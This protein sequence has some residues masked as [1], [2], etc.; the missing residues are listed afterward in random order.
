MDF[1]FIKIENVLFLFMILLANNET[2]ECQLII[3]VSSGEQGAVSYRQTVSGNL[4]SETVSVQWVTPAGNGVYQLTDFKA[5]VTITSI[6]VPGELDMGLPGYQ[7]FC[8]VTPGTG[9]IIPAE[10][11]FKLRQK[12]REAVRVAEE[13]K[14]RVVVDNSLSLVVSRSH[15]IS[16]HI[17][18]VCQEAKQNTFAPEQLMKDYLDGVVG[19]KKDSK[20]DV[21]SYLSF[22]EKYSG[23]RRCSQLGYE[24][25]EE[26]CL[27]VLNS[28][29][30]W[31]PCSLKYCRNNNGEAREHRCGIKTCSKCSELRF[32]SRSKLQCLWDEL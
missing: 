22:N 13:S 16:P 10:A 7:A 28:C 6:T 3:N 29:I 4:T 15:S 12:H 18:S 11:I 14:G 19:S 21:S 30:D 2:A 8:F 24:D 25:S 26:S 31:Y 17:A 5:G 20:R 27:C 9:D 1:P 32:S 23:L